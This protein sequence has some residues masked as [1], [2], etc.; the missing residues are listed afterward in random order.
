LLDPARLRST[1]W[2]GCRPCPANCP[3]N[4]GQI[5][6]MIS[7]GGDEDDDGGGGGSGDLKLQ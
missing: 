2:L 7:S 4:F 5:G 6:V 1:S 3:W